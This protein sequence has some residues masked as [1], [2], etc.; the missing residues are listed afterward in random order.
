TTC[1]KPWALLDAK[2]SG[3]ANRANAQIFFLII[4]LT[5]V[6][7]SGI[8]KP[9]FYQLSLTLGPYGLEPRAKLA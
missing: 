9:Y 1:F 3:T 4:S 5:F 7:P 8:N 2:D 6:S